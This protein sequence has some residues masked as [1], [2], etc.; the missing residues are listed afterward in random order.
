MYKLLRSLFFL[1]IF[2]NSLYG[3][4]II[5]DN[6]DK[7]DT[8]T[9]QY[10]YDEDSLLQIDDIEQTN[11][12][13]T[14]QNQFTQGYRYGNGWFKIDLTNKSD[15]EKFVLY[16]TE[17]IWST[18]DLYMKQKAGWIIQKNGLNV[19]LDKRGIQDSSPAF[20]F[21]LEK[22]ESVSLYIKGQTIA[23]QIGE[24]QIYT[25]EEYFNPNRITLAQWYITY[26][27]VLFAF[28]LLNVYNFMMTKES[29]YG[30]YVLY[31]FVY[32]VFISMHSGIYINF[33]FPN[34][35][36]GLHTIGQIT[37]LS[38]LLFSSEFLELKKTYPKMEKVFFQLSAGAFIF[39]VLLSQNI[40][41]A[42]VASN[43]Y[44]CGALITIV[45]VAI[46]VLKRG[47]E[48]AKYYLIALMLYLPS[49]TLMAMN[50]NTILPNT[51]ITRY[52]F[53][54]GAFLEIFLFTLILTNR[55]KYIRQLNSELTQKT[56]EL[57]TAKEQLKKE[58]I[59]DFLTNTYNRRYFNE[60]FPKV[61]NS[62]K[63][64]NELISFIIMDIDYFKQ[65]NDTYGHQMGDEV[66]NKVAVFIN[67][68]LHRSDDY[69]FRLGG[70]E[71]G[72]VFKSNTKE[73]AEKFAN[74]LRENIEKLQIEHSDSDSSP[75]VT[76]SMGLVSKNAVEIKND[77]AIYKETDDLLY[78]AKELGRNQL[79]VN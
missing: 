51:D 7:I 30:Y 62:A 43:I 42:T 14:I 6:I 78:K 29:I 18:L 63:R 10:F 33:G 28:I 67:N 22:G 31:V 48:G 34:W 64:N 39:A 56:K 1:L 2:F 16:F 32:I 74:T 58:S 26:A 65:Y 61:I 70:E 24:F 3:S 55:Y 79:C 66:L 47:F 35:Q 73:K 57:E 41:Y 11:F 69:C 46:V 44:F 52:S 53:L 12:T 37:L 54:G 15:N 68:N 25:Q 9:I 72:I 17:S 8:F 20:A 19:P 23:S 76:V 77:D 4:V 21:S 75:F 36:E 71:F 50:F 49:M 5:T 27:F 59:T 13:Q 45:Y 60:Y 40:P 38:L